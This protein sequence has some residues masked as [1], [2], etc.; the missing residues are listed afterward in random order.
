MSAT[1][2]MAACASGCAYH[3]TAGGTCGVCGGPLTAP[4]TMT[5]EQARDA[6][7]HESDGR[8]AAGKAAV[9]AWLAS[10]AR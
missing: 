10:R 3:S 7:L 5:R 4:V 1:Y 6:L 8:Y 9:L 2:Q